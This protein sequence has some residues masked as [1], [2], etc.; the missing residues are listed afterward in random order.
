MAG[1][2]ARC[3]DCHTFRETVAAFTAEARTMLSVVK[4]AVSRIEDCAQE[5]N[6]ESAGLTARVT[7]L[8]NDIMAKVAGSGKSGTGTGH[9]S[10]PSQ[11][12]EQRAA[13]RQ[14]AEDIT[15]RVELKLLEREREE[16]KEAKAAPVSP[17]A[18]AM[19]ASPPPKTL[20]DQLQFLALILGLVLTCTAMGSWLFRGPGA[21]DP[22]T[23]SV[24][25]QI[26]KQHQTGASAAPIAP[27]SPA[28]APVSSAPTKAH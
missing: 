23:A 16:A 9:P 22:E 5:L 27:F 11:A 8:E 1:D 6:R 15:A 10:V 7:R 28:P 2:D 18:A 26:V 24:L 14:L 20:R 25:K 21:I 3:S 17:P 13:E 12:A 19:S 4:D